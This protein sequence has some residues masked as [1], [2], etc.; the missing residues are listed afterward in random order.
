MSRPV[1]Q[2]EAMLMFVGHAAAMGTTELSGLH[3]TQGPGDVGSV[4]LQRA[5]P[6]SVVL[7]QLCLC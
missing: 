2:P 6:E 1:L 7:L 5:V 3:S 4:L